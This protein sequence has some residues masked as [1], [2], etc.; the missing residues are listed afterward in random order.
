[1]V[2]Y[3]QKEEKEMKPQRFVTSIVLFLAVTT[4]ALILVGYSPPRVTGQTESTPGGPPRALT[5]SL[6][7]AVTDEPIS[8]YIYGLFIE[9]Q[10]RCIYGGIWAE[11]IQDRKFYYTVN[12]YFPY[13][14]DMGK[15]PWRAI[16]YDTAVTMDSDHAYVGE[17]SPRI[18]LDGMKPRGIVQE[19]LALRQ[20]KGY[21]GRIVL[22][23]SDQVTVEVSL[24]WG[25]GPG[26]RQ[27]ITVG[28]LTQ[29]YAT[30]PLA[31]TAGVDTDNGRLE[32][33]SRGNGSFSI[34][35]VSVMPAD[36]VQGMR[37]DTLQLLKDL[38]ATV[39]RWPGGSFANGYDWHNAIGDRDKRPTTLNGAYGWEQLE[40]NDFG[41]DEFMALVQAL[42]ADPYVAVSAMNDG[43]VQLAA[44]EVQYFNGASDTPMGQLRAANGRSD[45]YGVRFWGIGN[46]AWGFASLSDYP[47]LNNRMAAA[48]RAVDSTITL[49]AVGGIGSGGQGQP[50]GPGKPDW[51][52]TM[53]T[54]TA[55]SM[56][57]ISEH[58]YGPP[59]DD[60]VVHSRSV[61]ERVREFSAIH[62]QYRQQLSSLQGKDVRLALDEWNY[63][64]GNQPLIYGDG[65]PRYRFRDALGI[66]AA[67][68]EMYR[69][70]D[71]IF[72][73]NTQA[74]NVLGQVK[75]TQTDAAIEVTGLA[76][77]LYRQHFGTLPVTISSDTDPLDVAAA[78]SS[79]HQALTVAVI[80]PTQDGYALTLDLQNAQITSAGRWWRIA[81]PDPMLYNEPGQP[82]R[83]MIE[84]QPL[85][86]VSLTFPVPP[87]SITL[88]E[89]PAQ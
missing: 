72:M 34:G 30:S 36:N 84:E 13:G 74:V 26:D 61:A 86:D 57:L 68:H 4:F 20:G 78:W 88:Y 11:M 71:L 53:L 6:D 69:N 45:P 1:M 63:F 38:G 10:G 85:P 73:A 62:R 87:L 2:R 80:N 42:G 50:A 44:D 18:T 12:Y 17:H 51:T 32:I 16:P 64:G 81:S 58:D 60:L 77:M 35:A 28:P 41:P 76:W 37:A 47:T 27:T 59:N 29:D 56:D 25:P 46:E 82:L 66:A 3:G 65:G 83:L 21:T 5:V 70:S 24:I 54:Q 19:G 23:S 49:I 22:A 33:V 15:S 39:Y 79:D 75:T 9:H 14:N 31:F 40:T 52:E 67:L 89:L 7:A 8:P 55:D 43:D 48:M